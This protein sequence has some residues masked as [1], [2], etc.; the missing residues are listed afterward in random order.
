MNDEIL[1]CFI[2]IA[3]E[4]DIGKAAIRLGL[5]SSYILFQLQ[6]LEDELGLVLLS[7][8]AP[9][10]FPT[11]AGK[12]FLPHAYKLALEFESIMQISKFFPEQEKSV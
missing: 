6:Q 4:N 3:E 7:R 9:C 2:V 10:I 5:S 8:G 12:A 11:A 1:R